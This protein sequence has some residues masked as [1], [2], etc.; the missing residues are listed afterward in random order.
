MSNETRG[1][2]EKSGQLHK[3][4]ATALLLDT[5]NK[6]ELPFHYKG[7][8]AQVLSDFGC[9]C[10]HHVFNMAVQGRKMLKKSHKEVIDE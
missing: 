6:V 4:E 3:K 10:T 7:G 9:V 2:S 1:R 5:L 8:W